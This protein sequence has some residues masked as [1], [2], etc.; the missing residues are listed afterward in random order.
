MALSKPKVALMWLSACGGCDETVV[1]LDLELLDIAEQVEL[2]LWPIALDHKY[3]AVRALAAAEIT[4]AIISGAV[5]NTE[6]REL[7]A[8]LRDKSK[9]VLALG[10][11]ACFGGTTGLANL[12]DFGGTMRWIYQEAP[13]VD[14]P[15]AVMPQAE[16]TVNG[17]VLSLPAM[18]DRVYPLNQVIAVDYY[19]PGCPPPPLLVA[20]ALKAVLSGDLPPKGSTLAPRRA[21]CDTCPRNRKKPQR[22]EIVTVR[23][24]HEVEADPDVCFLEQGILCLGPATRGGCGES[25]IRTNTPCRGCFGPVA[26]IQDQGARYINALASLLKTTSD[27]DIREL[28]ETIADPTGTFYRFTQPASIMGRGLTGPGR[29]I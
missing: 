7:A 24:I 14:N 9:M 21:L 18:L 12:E 15:E 25:C 29:S 6:Q 23:R 19:L 11:C 26:G 22:L 3:A 16:T 20:N 17:H 28:V 8:L 27:T 4:L 2:V 10:A 5:R 1:D 13:T